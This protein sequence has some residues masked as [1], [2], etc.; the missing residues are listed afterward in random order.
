MKYRL[1]KVD[2]LIELIHLDSP[3]YLSVEQRPLEDLNFDLNID[4]HF[5]ILEP[6]MYQLKKV[7]NE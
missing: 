7:V 5:L 4:N 6:L 3:K 2:E 1:Q